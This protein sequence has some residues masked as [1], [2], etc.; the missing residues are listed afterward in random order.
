M[1]YCVS[2]RINFEPVSSGVC[3]GQGD[4][5]SRIGFLL[6][7]KG[8]SARVL[9]LREEMILE[10]LDDAITTVLVLCKFCPE[11]QFLCAFHECTVRR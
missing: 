11:N 7:Q 8:T 1:W 4:A 3:E 9:L 5:S 6:K 10:K 2:S